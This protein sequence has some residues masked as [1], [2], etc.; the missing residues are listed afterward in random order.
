MGFYAV[1]R[2]WLNDVSSFSPADEAV[3]V[4]LSRRLAEGGFF[5]GYGPMA[6]EWLR[7]PSWWVYPNPLR[8]GHLALTT[9][10]VQ[11]RLPALAELTVLYQ[12]PVMFRMLSRDFFDDADSWR[13]A[14]DEVRRRIPGR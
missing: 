13:R 12:S 11:S 2:L 14:V 3:Y 8:C 6:R 9:I 7:D 10:A 5:S 1:L 4:D